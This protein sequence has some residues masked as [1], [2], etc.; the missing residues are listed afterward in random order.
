MA[1]RSFMQ[2]PAGVCLSVQ[3]SAC[4][5]VLQ[6]IAI[7]LWRSLLPARGQQYD[8]V[9]SLQSKTTSAQYSRRW[10]VQCIVG[11]R[12]TD[13]LNLSKHTFQ[14]QIKVQEP[15]VSFYL[16][17]SQRKV[18]FKHNKNIHVTGR[19]LGRWHNATFDGEMILSMNLPVSRWIHWKN[20]HKSI[21][22]LSKLEKHMSFMQMILS[23][24]KGIFIYKVTDIK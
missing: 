15:S 18:S 8:N 5:C 19:M 9:A 7:T 17:E 20:K 13:V 4:Y 6:T 11:Q 22:L 21:W 2:E 3:A 24:K 12:Y 10:R 14:Q 1:Q 16:T 23:I